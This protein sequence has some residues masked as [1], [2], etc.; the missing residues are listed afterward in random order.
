MHEFGNFENVVA[1]ALLIGGGRVKG[2]KWA[3]EKALTDISTKTDKAV[4]DLK[5]QRLFNG[6]AKLHTTWST[7]C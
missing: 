2:T 3:A 4:L 6:G 1:K 7:F 5:T